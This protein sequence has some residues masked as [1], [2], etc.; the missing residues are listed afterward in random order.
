VKGKSKKVKGK[1]FFAL[2]YIVFLRFRLYL[3]M[4]K[5]CFYGSLANKVSNAKRYFTIYV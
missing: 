2:K 4:L 5:N 1:I 3:E